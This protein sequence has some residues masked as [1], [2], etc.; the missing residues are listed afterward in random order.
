MG[1]EVIYFSAPWCQPCRTLG[2][3][4][5]ELR[6]QIDYQKVNVDQ[7]TELA[8]KYGIRNIPTLLFLKNG[9]VVNRLVGM[10]TKENILR[11]YN[12]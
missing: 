4:M 7:D 11:T 12:G 10:Q 8:A 5:E 9:N 2:P 6:G 1:K 3:I